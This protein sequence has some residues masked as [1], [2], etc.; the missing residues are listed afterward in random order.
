MWGSDFVGTLYIS[1][2]YSAA[3]SVI[4]MAVMLAVVAVVAF[5]LML[6]VVVLRRKKTPLSPTTS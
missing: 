5:I 6:A 1:L 4:V 3:D 2:V